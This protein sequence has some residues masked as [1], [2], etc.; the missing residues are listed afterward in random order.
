MRHDAPTPAPAAAQAPG[1]RAATPPGRVAPAPCAPAPAAPDADDPP[2]T[3]HR[4]ITLAG[5]LSIVVGSMLGIGI[6]L[7]PGEMAR[8]LP[9]PWSFLG[10]WLVAGLI[11]LGG[12]AAY[13]ELGTRFPH[14]GGDYVFHREA[15]GPSAAFATGWALFGAIFSGSIAAVAVALFE[16]QVDA[17]L[18][19][20][21]FHATL[22]VVPLVGEVHVAQVA[23]VVLVLGLTLLNARGVRPSAVTQQ[24]MTLLPVAVLFVLALA[25]LGFFAGG[26]LELHET[27]HSPPPLSMGGLV[28]AYLAA[29]FA[30]SGWNAVIYVA[31]EV[32]APKRNI[33]RALVGGTLAVTLLY[34]A[35]C[36]AFVAVLGLGGLA[37]GGEAGSQLAAALLGEAGGVPMNILVLL[38]LLA[39][40]NGSVLS[41]ARVAYAMALDGALWRGARKLDARSGAPN[42]ALW[43]QAAWSSVLILTNS[44]EALLVGVSLT[45]VVTGSLT[46][47][48]LFRVR[49]RDGGPRA[50]RFPGAEALIWLFLASSALVLGVKV[51]EGV[52]GAGSVGP[53]WG[54]GVGLLAFLVHGLARRRRLPAE[55]D[56]GTEAQRH[57]G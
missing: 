14:A 30:Y 16:F 21:D 34:L 8:S 31:G 56:A 6:F 28:T 25:T 32:R 55:P 33:P 36:G 17:L 50:V 4:S 41:G 40:L 45:M 46:V 37:D 48:A 38:C 12:A 23:G 11:V 22:A 20:V 15:F 1:E 9:G 47:L 5:A 39:T 24:I 10:V 29:Y 35:L 53:L 7:S 44:F 26:Q 2:G 3:Q 42:A 49:R 13:A 18:P 54:L 43:V 57:E 52:T 19:T 51:H 27:R